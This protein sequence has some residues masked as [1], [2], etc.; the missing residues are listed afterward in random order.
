MRRCILCAYARE[1]AR[2]REVDDLTEREREE[3]RQ[4]DNICIQSHTWSVN[5]VPKISLGLDLVNFQCSSVGRKIRTKASQD[6]GPNRRLDDS[7]MNAS[8]ECYTYPVIVY[9]AFFYLQ[10]YTSVR[11]DAIC[12]RASVC[13]NIQH[14]QQD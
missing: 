12:L 6:I 11:R 8:I 2:E 13:M 7:H 10:E 3:E 5:I 1:R 4:T 14:R 9:C